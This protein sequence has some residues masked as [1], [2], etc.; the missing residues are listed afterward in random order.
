MN[1]KHA[2]FTLSKDKENHDVRPQ[3]TQ[4][5]SWVIPSLT[6]PHC[7]PLQV[8]GCYL[9]RSCFSSLGGSLLDMPPTVVFLIKEAFLHRE[10]GWG[11]LGAS[12]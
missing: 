10:R 11:V 5:M 1:E 4:L 3:F 9:S 7:S 12:R 2:M 6:F 8:F